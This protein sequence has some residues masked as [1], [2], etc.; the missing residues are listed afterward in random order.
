MT[1]RIFINAVDMDGAPVHVAVQQGRI[2]SMGSECPVLPHAEVVDVAGHVLLPGFVDGH[3]HLDKSFVG[4]RWH[5][6]Q[7]VSS[8]RERLA[9]EKQALASA[10]PMVARAEALMAQAAGFGTM[11]MRCH[12]D[13]DATTQLT[14]LEAVLQ[15]HAKWEQ[16][17]EIELVAFPQAGVVSCPGTA[18][19]LDQAMRAGAQVVG[20]IDPTT[21]DG[22]PDRQLDVVFDL[23]ERHAAKVDVHLHEPG[24][25]CMADLQRI[26]AR[27]EALGMQGRVAVSHA[28]GLGDLDDA[29]LQ[30]IAEVLARAGIAIMTN[31]P[32]NHGFPPVLKLR[33]AGVR[34]FSGNDNIQD[35]WWPFG[36]GDMLQRAMLVAYRSGFYTDADLRVAL[37]MA[38][39][40]SAAVMGKADYGLQPGHAADFVLVQAPN[41]AAAVATAPY[42]R[43]VVR[44]GEIWQL[45]EAV[46]AR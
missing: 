23:A 5:S 10:R 7:P 33:E 4:D 37:D 12:V 16:W 14:H 29:A 36:N 40:A 38:T 21:F 43:K 8:L 1:D 32:G 9:V 19:V 31:A 26:A 11:A 42:A 27:T 34:V 18:Q 30:R 41:A 44:K 46:A 13:V 3:I 22:D 2:A 20:G 45:P 24:E 35:A 28:Y 6:H 25:I 15:A 17:L 39:H